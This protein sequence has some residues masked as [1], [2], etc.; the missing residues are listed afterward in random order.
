MMRTL[1]FPGIV[2][3][4]PLHNESKLPFI[5][6]LFLVPVVISMTVDRT[7]LWQT[8]IFAL[9]GAAVYFTCA[10]Y[11]Q[12]QE[13]WAIIFKKMDDMSGGSLERKPTHLG[14]PFGALQSGL[15]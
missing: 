14:G 1:F 7:L 5:T 2:F 4:R 6:A 11:F 15:D 8:L 9:Y 13:D 12:A 10:Y 3:M